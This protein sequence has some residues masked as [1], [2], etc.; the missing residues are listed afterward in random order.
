MRARQRERERERGTDK[1]KERQKEEGRTLEERRK[2][3]RE[4][5]CTSYLREECTRGRILHSTAVAC[6]MFNSLSLSLCK[7]GNI[8]Q[9]PSGATDH[10]QGGRG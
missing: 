6:P 3:G 10:M 5:D 9:H 7:M 8:T 1:G 2:G 4:G